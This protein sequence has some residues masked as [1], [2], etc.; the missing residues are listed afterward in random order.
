MSEVVIKVEAEMT[1][2][3]D[4][5]KS[6]MDLEFSYINTYNSNVDHIPCLNCDSH[7]H[8]DDEVVKVTTVVKSVTGA[9]KDVLDKVTALLNRTHWVPIRIL[10]GPLSF[11]YRISDKVQLVSNLT[12]VG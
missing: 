5:R 2:A 4:T 3:K 1:I 8:C 10:A 6:A 9:C 11:S 12:I 7:I